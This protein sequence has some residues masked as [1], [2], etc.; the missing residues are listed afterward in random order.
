MSAPL[1][2]S[3]GSAARSP[4]RSRSRRPRCTSSC[5][6]ASG[7]C[8]ARSSGSRATAPPSRSTK[9]RPVS[10]WASRSRSPARRSPCSSVPACWDRCWTAWAGRWP[11]SPRRRGTSSSPARPRRRSTPPPAGRSRRSCHPAQ[12][13]RG[14]DVLGTV[15]ERPGFAAPRARAA[16]RRGHRGRR[17]LG[18]L[19]H[20][21]RRGGPARRRHTPRAGARLAGARAAPVGRRLA[22][23]APFVTGQRVFDFLFPVAEGGSVAVPGGFGT[24]KTVIEQSLAKYADADVVVYV[25]CGERGNEMAEVLEEFPRLVDPRTGRSIMDRTVLVVNTS[26]MPVAAREASVYLGITIAEYYRDMGYRVALMADSLS[27]WAEALRE[28]GARLQEMPGEEGYPTYLGNRLGKFYERAGRVHAVGAPER[29]GAVTLISAISPPG[30]DFSEPVTQAAL[31]VAGAL[32]ALDAALAHQRQFPAVDWE[33]SYSL[34]TRRDH[35]LVRGARRGGL[36]RAAARDPRAAAARPRAARDRRAGRARGAAGRRPPAARGGADGPRDGAGAERLRPERRALAAREDLPAR[37][38]GARAATTPGARRWTR[39]VP[40][41]SSTSPRRG[42]LLAALRRAPAAEVP[43]RA[44]ERAGAR[45]RGVGVMSGAVRR[46]HGAAGVAGP[47]LY[48]RRTP[49][50]ALGEWVEIRAPGQ[51]PRRGQVIDA[52]REITVIQV[53]EDTVGLPPARS[54]VTLTGEVATAI[55]GRELLGR[56]LN[57]IGAADRRSAR[58]GGRGAASGLGR[59]AQ[60]GAARAPGRLHRDRHLRHRRHE[61]AGARPEAPGVLRSRAARRSSWRPASW[62]ARARRAASRSPSSSW[63]S[64]SPRARPTSSSTGSS[65]AARG[66]AACST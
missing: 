1:P 53:L 61:H 15:E 8:S 50:V 37:G 20:R 42:A 23:G 35:A 4:R 43:A 45:W 62:K 36:G 60:P 54:E 39:G 47:L 14:G 3:S 19:I 12:R 29:E 52:G 55:V 16:G 25:G 40:S 66:S 18:G 17:R 32:W 48:V 63:G 51:P 11:G 59:A 26:N 38:P 31:R 46:Y 41:S 65:G 56:A 7:A 28:I 5:G 34:Y 6:S 21:R 49:T 64:A 27:R 22:L 2:P 58:P 44:A 57:G 13:C 30:G 9:R 10:R 33:T 24:G